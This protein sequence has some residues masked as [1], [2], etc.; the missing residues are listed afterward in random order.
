MSDQEHRPK[1]QPS[2]ENRAALNENKK[3]LPD[4]DGVIEISIPSVNLDS[5]GAPIEF[6]LSIVKLPTRADQGA[7]IEFIT[8][9]N[10]GDRLQSMFA[11]ARQLRSLA[12]E[13][14][15]AKLMEI[16]KDNV[17][18]AFDHVIEELTKT[19]PLLAEWVANNTGL[20]SAGSTPLK[21]SEIVNNRYA[22]CR[23]LSTALLA[24]AHEAGLEGSYQTYSPGI[25]ARTPYEYRL[26]NVIREDNGEPLFKLAPVGEEIGAH[27][28]VELKVNGK[29]V[30]YDPSTMLSGD[31]DEGL[32]TFKKANYRAIVG[33]SLEIE[34]L[35][36]EVR[37]LG[38]IDLAVPVASDRHSGTLKVNAVAKEKPFRIVLPG[39]TPPPEDQR[40]I[41]PKHQTYSG[42]LNLRVL[43]TPNMSGVNVVP[44]SVT[45]K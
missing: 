36:K 33:R 22:I 24:L 16:L 23:H 19:D 20:M 2:T 10:E 21:L 12:E 1:I 32:A 30:P 38:M 15:P 14:R 27:A 40:E 7:V 17:E 8:I 37:A 34:G 9:D 3:V 29:W 39:Q 28:W 35:P 44:E 41:W 25:F 42:E 13:E 11:K 4:S 43:S 31:T 18:Y 26:N 45:L 5:K 6:E